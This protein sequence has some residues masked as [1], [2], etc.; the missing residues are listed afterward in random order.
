M[1]ILLGGIF[2]VFTAGA[3]AKITGALLIAAAIALAV[4]WWSELRQAFSPVAILDDLEVTLLKH[5]EDF[6]GFMPSAS[7]SVSGLQ[8]PDRTTLTGH[9]T[10]VEIVNHDQTAP[11]EI[12]GMRLGL[13][14]SASGKEIPPHVLELTLDPPRRHI[15]PRSRLICRLGFKASYEGYIGRTNPAER[16]FLMIRAIGL[17]SELKVALRED[18]FS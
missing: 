1:T 14:D 16:V 12:L 5:E 2:L 7:S 9:L 10:W 18:F 13:F 4:L 17:K 3:P 8:I 6:V 15:P 11:T